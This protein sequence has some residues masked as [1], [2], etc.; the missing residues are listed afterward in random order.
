MLKRNLPYLI[1][2]LIPLFPSCE[3]CE[4]EREVRVQIDTRFT[5]SYTDQADYWDNFDSD[6]V[7]YVLVATL[8]SEFPEAGQ[9][10]LVD[11]LPDYILRIEKLD[12]I[13]EVSQQ[14]LE[15][16]CQEEETAL[17]NFVFGGPETSTFTIHSC[18]VTAA[19]IL[20][21]AHTDTGKRFSYAGISSE[22]VGQPPSSDTINCN[23]YR[24]E[25][26][27]IPRYACRQL[28]QKVQDEIKCRIKELIR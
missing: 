3:K 5:E 18:R 9:I 22:Q 13:G 24:V 16:P 1:L 26:E 28:G 15:D 25:G 14:T 2:L 23:A 6:S 7:L 27:V 21:D 19:L 4:L 11:T 10:V 20:F 12:A 17:H 8:R